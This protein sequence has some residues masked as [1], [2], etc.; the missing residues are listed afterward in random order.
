MRQFTRRELLRDG[1]Y[2]AS[3]L[4]AMYILAA[5]G[6]GGNTSKAL[7]THLK[8]IS[9]Y[10][11]ATIDWG[12]FSGQTLTLGFETHPFTTGIKPLIPEF[13]Q[14]TGIKVDMQVSNEN[15]LLQ[16][17]SV[18]LSSGQSTPDVFFL[19]NLGQYARAGWIQPL[20]QYLHN[21]K[22]TDPS[23]YKIHDVFPAAFRFA[24]YRNHIYG[25][26]ITAEVQVLYYW[27]NILSKYGL[28]VP[29][30]FDQL[31]A[32]AKEIK[33]RAGIAGI[34]NRGQR[35]SASNPW[36]W[37]GYEASFGGRIFDP[38]GKPVLN[39]AANIKALDFYAE[40][41]REAG[42]IGAANMSWSD[43]EQD[44]EA[45]KVAMWTDSSDFYGSITSAVSDPKN[46]GM[47]MFPRLGSQ[48][49]TPN[50]WFWLLGMNRKSTVKDAAWLFLE[51]A[52]S[53]ETV[54]KTATTTTAPQRESAWQ[55]SSMVKLE[56]M[57]GVSTVIKGL[58]YASAQHFPWDNPSWPVVGDELSGAISEAIN[59]QSAKS[60]LDAA[61]ANSLKQMSV[62]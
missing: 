33:Q 38:S 23:W 36:P 13:E 2:G 55:T 49:P 11:N 60:V 48:N 35:G 39:S 25:M 53:P 15:E 62:S 22:L 45:K 59:G 41:L 1:A 61:Q 17:L 46:V 57:T 30:T 12:Q 31:L 51:W 24:T 50:S 34:G 40:L 21:K 4:G 19:E 6:V 28:P 20:D 44:F 42:P 8:K 7:S 43:V 5:C 27:K 47:V 10:S 18:A 56:G 52:T 54:A 3:A 14:L 29:T 9:G 37:M 16:K 58:Q 26:P 32:T